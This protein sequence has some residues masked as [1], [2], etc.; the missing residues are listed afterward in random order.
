M[1]DD[2]AQD[3]GLLREFVTES[4]EQ[5]Q[6]MEQD[7]LG[8]EG[9]S[10]NETL[11]RIFRAMHTIKGTSSFL[12]FD[13]IVEL[14]H[15]AEDVLNA[16]R[17]EECR[18][19]AA[20]TDVMLRV[21]DRVRAMLAD[22]ANHRELQYDNAS[23]IVAL[24]TAHE[25]ANHVKLGGILS[26]QPVI[27]EADL[28][29]ALAESQSTGKK[30]GQV[31]V[32]H[33]I[34]TPTHI[35]QALS[36]QGIVASVSDNT[37]MRVDVRKLDFL[38]NLVGE[39][40]LERNRLVQLSR[41]VSGGQISKEQMDG[42]LNSSATRLSFITDELQTAS[43]QT[44]M[45]PI[46]TVFRRLPRM[47]RDVAG[48]LGKHV[49]LVIRGQETEIDKT[50]V[51]QISD[52]L[53]HLVR[54]AI[55][56]GIET[57]E[58][59]KAAGK[60][61]NGTLVVEARPEGDQIVICVADDGKGIDPELVLAKT[62]EKGFVAAERAKMLSRR[63]ILDL[64]FLP[65][66]STAEKVNNV[67]GRGVGMDVVRSNVKKLNGTV[68]LESMEGKGTTI[69]IRAPL[70][71]AILPVLLVGVGEEV[72]A[73][74]LHAVQ[75][76]VRVENADL[77]LVD[78][79]EVLCLSGC[80][81]SVLRLGEIFSVKGAQMQNCRAVILALGDM[82]IALLVDRLLGQESTVIKPMGEFLREAPSITGAT[83]G[84]DG[85]VRLVLD[86]AS[87]VETAKR[88]CAGRVQ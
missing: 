68:E 74:P 3:E 83:I 25:G 70:T 77:H 87:L 67:S 33:E 71:M 4:E 52:P 58:K 79:R 32:E 30:L 82:R 34:A 59:R 81:V 57:A 42:A 21:C 60:L 28:N 73:L 41:E 23:L 69:R 27:E 65:G 72:Y 12:Q 31:L 16:M 22:V 7:L 20:I 43:L 45:V 49:E 51:E 80:T 6:S 24:K 15:E 78:G 2:L 56:H 76:T 84:G 86:P 36:K 5:L 55:D 48:A 8:I 54:N 35:E 18:P 19:T 11:N 64:I 9:G 46:E 47:V 29:A 88:S 40:V 75:E 85:R 53:V 61:E 14:T 63:E 26:T 17:R 44:R 38:V 62:V 10:D 50:M 39:L 37:T 13:F 1:S 66:M